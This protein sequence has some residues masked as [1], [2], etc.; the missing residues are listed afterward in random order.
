MKRKSCF[1]FDTTGSRAWENTGKSHNCTTSVSGLWCIHR[2]DWEESR[3]EL[4]EKY[5]GISEKGR[6]K[7][8]AVLWFSG[9]TMKDFDTAFGVKYPFLVPHGAGPDAR[10]FQDIRSFLSKAEEKP[11]TELADFLEEWAKAIQYIEL[12][13]LLETASPFIVFPELGTK[14]SLFDFLSNK[15]ADWWQRLATSVDVSVN[16]AKSSA[17]NSATLRDWAR[18]FL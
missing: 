4:R 7:D 5:V 15:D 2:G 16:D 6:S 11:D 9:D 12:R 10:F 3:K 18:R 14:S 1:Y 13:E 17:E 8:I